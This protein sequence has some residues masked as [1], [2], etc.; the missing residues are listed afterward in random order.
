M[1]ISD[2]KS[3]ASIDGQDH[4]YFINKYSDHLC[5]VQKMYCHASYCSMTSNNLDLE[6][7][8]WNIEFGIHNTEPGTRDI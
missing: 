3:T 8:M 2:L 1:Y 4:F 5:L 6:F 7:G